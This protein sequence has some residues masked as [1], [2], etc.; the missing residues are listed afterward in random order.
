VNG[1]GHFPQGS[2]SPTRGTKKDTGR[3]RS[4]RSARRQAAEPGS[5][6]IWFNH[7]RRREA[8]A[9]TSRRHTRAAIHRLPARSKG[10]L[11]GDIVVT[12]RADDNPNIHFEKNGSTEG[13]LANVKGMIALKADTYVTGHG[14][15]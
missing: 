4:W 12:N 13:W 8:R 2:K 14:I 11:E 9:N 1:L 7:D 6:H 3:R 5:D 15:C 10:R